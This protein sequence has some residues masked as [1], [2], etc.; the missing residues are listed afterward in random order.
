MENESLTISVVLVTVDGS[1]VVA[2]TAV[3][4]AGISVPITRDDGGSITVESR[5]TVTR[6]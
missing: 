1:G 6:H 3:A 5:V 2:V 4:G